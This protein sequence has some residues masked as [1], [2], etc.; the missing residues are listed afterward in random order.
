MHVKGEMND[1]CDEIYACCVHSMH[2]AMPLK[3]A[4]LTQLDKLEAFQWTRKHL[5][6]HRFEHLLDFLA[7]GRIHVGP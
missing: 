5:G 6:K 2:M 3:F 4:I 7:P 1:Y